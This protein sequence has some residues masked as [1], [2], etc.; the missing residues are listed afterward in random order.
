MPIERAR[1]HL[2]ANNSSV[3]TYTLRR[4]GGTWRTLAS[5]N[6]DPNDFLAA[7]LGSE[8]IGVSNRSRYKSPEMDALLKRGRLLP[9]AQE[10]G[11]VYREAQ[12]ALR[13]LPVGRVREDAARQ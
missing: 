8:S 1:F 6:P 13:G 3:E 7:L 4:K 11:A 2:A 10:R 9:G 12:L 5:P